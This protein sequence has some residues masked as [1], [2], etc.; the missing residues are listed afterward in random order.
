M[1]RSIQNSYA[2]AMRAKRERSDA[3]QGPRTT[4]RERL[5]QATMQLLARQG[6]AGTGIKQILEHADAQFSS[7]YHHFPGGKEELAAEALRTAGA[8]YQELV[9]T[10]WDGEATVLRSIVAVFEGAAQALADSD[11]EDVCPI[12]TVAS[13]VA[14]TNETLRTA[15]AEV[16]RSWVAGA[17]ERLQNAGLSVAEAE[18]L[19][20]T[21]VTLLEG[22]FVLCR[23]TRSVNPMTVGGGIAEQL[24]NDALKVVLANQSPVTD[25]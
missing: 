19:A 5:L 6:L 16:Y 10:V 8:Q 21:I 22:A 1:E 20:L 12:G 24:V 23:A 13:E 14:S 17:Q 7:L 15:I 11:Y 2:R 4:T 3:P 18:S 9:E 25:R